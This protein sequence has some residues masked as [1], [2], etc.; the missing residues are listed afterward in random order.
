VLF[1]H[2]TDKSNILTST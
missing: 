2:S 1:K